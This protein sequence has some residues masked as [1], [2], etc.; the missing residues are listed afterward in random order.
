MEDIQLKDLFQM[1]TKRWWILV[2]TIIISISF[3]TI[4][5]YWYLKPIYKASTTIYIGREEDSK[6]AI[7][8]S[9]IQLGQ[10]LV[11]DYSELVKS[12]LVAGLAA[13]EMKKRYNVNISSDYISSRL[14]VNLKNDT[15]LIQITV[16][17]ENP[18]MAQRIADIVSTVFNEKVVI[19]KLNVKNVWPIDKAELP[20]APFKPNHKLNIIISILL[21]SMIG[22][23]IIVLLDYLD[24]TIKTP[25][26]IQKHLGLPV[27]GTIPIFP[28]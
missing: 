6:A 27:I 3:A 19:A 28:E 16:D 8:I 1:V 25:D 17:D 5:T 11:K 10:Q 4:Y 9:D 26:D 14:N 12:R 13:A 18:K 7:G 21:G 15:R 23:G 20:T 24:N 22:V 2:I